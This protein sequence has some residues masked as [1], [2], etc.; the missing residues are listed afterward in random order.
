MLRVCL[1]ALVGFL[2]TT[3]AAQNVTAVLEPDQS[4]ELRSTVNGR[5]VETVQRE[6]TAVIE[7]QVVAKIDAAVQEARVQLAKVASRSKRH[8]TAAHRSSLNRP[9]FA[10]TKF[11]KPE[12]TVQ[13]KPG[14]S[15]SL[16]KRW[17]WRRRIW[18]L[19]KMNRIAARRNWHWKRQRWPSFSIRAPFDGIVLNVDVDPG[20]IVDTATVLVEIGALDRLLATAFVPVDWVKDLA[21]GDPLKVSLENGA[22]RDATVRAI[23]PRVDPASRTIRLLVEVSNLDQSMRPGEVLVIE[24]PL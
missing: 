17:Q 6:G 18:S 2:P 10:K 23:D 3:L 13:R 16:N 12:T 7:G 11:G 1:L 15:M 20:E 4:V 24:N 19:R 21:A 9:S 8:R 5:V 22:A 14:K